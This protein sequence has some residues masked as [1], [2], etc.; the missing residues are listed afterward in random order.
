M[1]HYP[2]RPKLLAPAEPKGSGLKT[3]DTKL[4]GWFGR[5][6]CNEG[7]EFNTLTENSTKRWLA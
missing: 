3:F 6:A 5:V 4:A 2:R 1:H 7:H